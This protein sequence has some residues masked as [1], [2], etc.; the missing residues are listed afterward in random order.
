MRL[1]DD[2]GDVYA[3]GIATD[4]SALEKTE[5]DLAP[6]EPLVARTRR[7]V[8]VVDTD[9]LYVLVKLAMEGHRRAACRRPS[10]TAHPQDTALRRRRG[11]RI[12]TPADSGDRGA[13]RP[14]R[15]RAPADR[16]GY[17]AHLAYRF[18]T[19]YWRRC[20]WEEFARNRYR[21]E[22]AARAA[23]DVMIHHEGRVRANSHALLSINPDG[24]GAPKGTASLLPFTAGAVCGG[25]AP[26]ADG[27]AFASIRSRCCS[28]G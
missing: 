21:P 20:K 3:L 23:C 5:R 28:C 2:R 8:D 18:P 27:P 7:A 25:F 11:D 19:A 1:L 22:F 12:P 13:Q 14:V 24:V 4:H 9:L 10:R 26:A 17:R 6:S 15:G 16:A